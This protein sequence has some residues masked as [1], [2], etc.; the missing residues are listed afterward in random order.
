[1]RMRRSCF[2]GALLLIGACVGTEESHL[3]G[4]S[5]VAIDSTRLEETDSVYL[6]FPTA[7]LVAPTGDLF[8]GDAASGRV[9][10]YDAGGRLLR[11][12]S[13]KGRGPGEFTVP[14]AMTLVDEGHLAVA[15]W[16]TEE[17]Q[18]LDLS[19]GTATRRVSTAGLPY[20]ATA[21]NDTVFLGT[22]GRGARRTS[23]GVIAPGVDSLIRFGGLPSEYI[24]SPGVRTMH[25]YVSL[26][27]SGSHFVTGFTGANIVFDS[28]VGQGLRA[29]AVPSTRR[30]PM[31]N[32]R[33]MVEKFNGQLSDSV[34]AGMG[35]TLIGAFG[36]G[37]D[38]LLLVHLDVVLSKQLLTAD[39]WVSI[40]DLDQARGCVDTRV[41]T[42]KAGKP[43]FTAVADTLVM[44]EQRLTSSNRPETWVLRYRVDSKACDWLP[45]LPPDTAQ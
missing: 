14:G 21:R 1:M 28:V 29:F 24:E 31:P 25:P 33:G 23:G 34:I 16:Q 9:L 18:W 13:G 30:R 8:V 42:S 45:F 38:T 44:L 27:L 6:S 41:R 2:L 10:R 43:I 11:A 36:G 22:L 39:A 20:T 7:V 4:P 37:R 32:S 19:N 40:L 17:V 12:Y 15:D 35:S 3:R 26:A 5:V